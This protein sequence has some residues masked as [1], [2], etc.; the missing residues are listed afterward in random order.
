MSKQKNI[1]S[2][3]KPVVTKRTSSEACENLEGTKKLKLEESVENEKNNVNTFEDKAATRLSSMTE[4]LSVL[5]PNMGISWFCALE[6]EL[7]K[8]YFKKLS[9]YVLSERMKYTVY[10]RPDNV[11]SWT[12]MCPISKI[13]VVILGQDPYHNPNQA[14][15]L[16]FSVPKGIQPPPSLLNMYK[17]LKDDINDFV[18]PDHGDLTSWAKQGVL[19]LN[20]CLTVRQNSPNSHADKGWENITNAV[21]KYISDRSKGVVFLL[22][23]SYAQKKASCVDQKKHHLLK[24]VHPSPLSAHR[25]FFGC[26][27]F[28]KCNKLLK[29]E[30][31]EPIDWNS[32][33]QS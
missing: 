14:H 7:K 19:L 31:K 11:W 27:H 13:K 4:E 17:E 12:K 8:P 30:G 23:G 20:A 24:T 25:G 26:K 10:P 33:N 5:D 18:V 21:I 32:L 29:D 2:F 22:W 16:C 6:N 15:G 1:L 3:F 9:E 28:S